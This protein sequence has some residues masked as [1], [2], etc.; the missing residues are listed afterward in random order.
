MIL[1]DLAQDHQ[2]ERFTISDFEMPLWNANVPTYPYHKKVA[3]NRALAEAWQWLQN[4]GLIMIDLD[5]PNGWFCLTRKGASL[6]TQAD[7]EA[8]RHGNVL[9]EGLMYPKLVGKVRPMFLRGDYDVAVIQ[10]FKY[11]EVA[12]RTAT[13]LP[14]DMVGQK[15]MRAAFQPENGK[16][17]DMD[18]PQAERQAVMELFSGAMGHGRNPPSH[19]DVV[20]KRE[21]AA[22]LIGLASYLL[23]LVDRIEAPRSA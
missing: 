19:R 15:L 3:V 4:E 22:Q 5:Q 11:V 7:I 10:A 6:K 17:T 9:P 8:Y 2:G 14:E 16:L 13:K 20:I 18:S 12:V 21:N 23:F 1:L